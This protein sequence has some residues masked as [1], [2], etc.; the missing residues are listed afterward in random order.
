[1]FF[2]PKASSVRKSMVNAEKTLRQ[3]QLRELKQKI[4]DAAAQGYERTSFH[5]PLDEKIIADLEKKGYKVE[6]INYTYF[7]I[8]W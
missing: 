4:L 5:F 7:V 2:M 3:K 8:S 1:M 6:A